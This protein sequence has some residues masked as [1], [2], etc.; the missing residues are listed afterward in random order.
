M[1]MQLPEDAVPISALQHYLYCPRQCALIHV[2]RQWDENASTADGRVMH[3]KV[4]SVLS[5]S[6]GNR[7]TVNGLFLCSKE[8]GLFGQA[9]TVEFFKQNG[10][11]QPYPVEHKLGRPKHYDADRIQ[12][13]AQAICLEEMLEMPVPEG[14][15]FYGKIRR[16]EIVIFDAELRN[17]TQMTALAVHH[18]L[19]EGKTPPVPQP[20]RTSVI[21]P[22]CSLIEGCMPYLRRTSVSSYLKAIVEEGR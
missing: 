21:C 7:K 11:W 18:L 9:D 20:E 22:E 6:R 12:L 1:L 4:H 16:R 14:S 13:C 5:E 15:L 17:K 3:E 10:I 19:H 8:L 2:E